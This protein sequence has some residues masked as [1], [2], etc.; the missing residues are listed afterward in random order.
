MMPSEAISSDKVIVT[1]EYKREELPSLIKKYNVGVVFIP[2][3]WP[4]TFSFTTEE[5]MMMELPLAV[6]DIGAPPER[7]RNYKKGL[8]IEKIEA[9]Y[10]LEELLKFTEN[11]GR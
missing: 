11:L 1:G 6:F 9:A 3:I 4:E 8:V 10:A 5:I 2:S 7:V